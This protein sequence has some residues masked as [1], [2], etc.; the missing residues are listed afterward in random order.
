ML[1]FPFRQDTYSMIAFF[2]E[3]RGLKPFQYKNKRIDTSRPSQEI[4]EKEK[5]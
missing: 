1:L 5:F 3:N 2:L 4:Y